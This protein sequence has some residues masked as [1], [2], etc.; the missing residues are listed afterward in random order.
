MQGD[1]DDHEDHGNLADSPGHL[2][3]ELRVSQR[4]DHPIGS[5]DAVPI[6]GQRLRTHHDDDGKESMD[7]DHKQNESEAGD[8]GQ[9]L[10]HGINTHDDPGKEIAGHDEVHLHRD[11]PDVAP[12]EPCHQGG[13]I[14]R[15]QA[16]AEDR[17]DEE[18]IGD[19]LSD[20]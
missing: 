18:G 20:R 15:K 19:D 1:H 7:A 4:V 12:H 17:E 16:Q 14:E 3:A 5:D 6:L 9:R 10:G 11:V 8:V 2:P 13:E